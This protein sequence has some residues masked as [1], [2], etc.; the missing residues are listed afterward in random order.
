MFE[1]FQTIKLEIA[2]KVRSAI[3]RF[4]GDDSGYVFSIDVLLLGTILVIGSLVGHTAIRDALNSELAD[5]ATAMENLSSDGPSSFEDTTDHCDDPEDSVGE[6]DNCIAFDSEPLDEGEELPPIGKVF[7]ITEVGSLDF[8]DVNRGVGGSA[9]GT[10]GDA[11]HMTGFTVTTDTGN[12]LGTSGNKITFAETP[13]HAGTFTT[14]FAEPMTDVEFWV[15]NVTNITSNDNLLGNFT[16]TLSDGT[17]LNNAAFTVVP[18]VI[19]PNSTY[20][21]FTTGGSDRESLQ[22]VTVG[23]AQYVTDP[24][25]NGPGSQSAGRITFDNVP[26]AGPSPGNPIGITSISFERSGGP[27]NYRAFFGVSGKV[28]VCEE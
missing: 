19:N 15:Q 28:I 11:S 26:A 4:V 5:L 20:G 3:K 1:S 27:N 2:A 9:T 22:V 14:S 25:Q 12:I 6:A 21:E 10:I 24:T 13:N 23:G 8:T 17:V 16:V 7:E 18:D